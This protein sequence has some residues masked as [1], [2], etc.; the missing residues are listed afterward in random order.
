MA[1]IEEPRKRV[2][3]SDKVW[4]TL[5]TNNKYLPGLLTLEHSLRAVGSAYPLLVL[6]TDTLEASGH[7]ALARRGIPTQRIEY[8]L[9]LASKDY[10]NDTRF[11]DCW[12]KLQPFGFTEY[13]RVAQ[14]DSDMLVLQNMDELM[15]IPLDTSPGST[16]LFAAAHACVCNPLKHPHYPK[17]WVPENC[18]Y[19]SQ[20]ATPDLAAQTGADPN[21]GLGS[22]NG[23]LQVV[24]PCMDTYRT[25]ISAISEPEKTSGY[26]FADQSLLG[27]AFAGRWAPLSYRYNALKTLRWCHK[28]I[29][30]DDEVKNVHYILAPKPWENRESDDETHKWWWRANEQRVLEEKAKGI[31]D[32]W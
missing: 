19:T 17:D 23:G 11:Y 20:H 4:T 18:A 12:S 5:L 31:A 8:L 22:L 27:D 3:D 15:D 7:E 32:G 16:R 24:V 6:Y 14:L 21:F 30:R 29:W 2:V 10:S 13:S 9:P 28:E 26:D 25:I 1:P